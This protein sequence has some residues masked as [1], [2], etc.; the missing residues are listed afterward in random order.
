M[1]VAAT[2]R[3]AAVRWVQKLRDLDASETCAA[4]GP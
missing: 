2:F 1:K 3:T 4:P